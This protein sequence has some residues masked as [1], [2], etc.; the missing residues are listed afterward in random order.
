MNN[1]F[2]SVSLQKKLLGSFSFVALICLLVGLAGWWGTSQLNANLAAISQD[3]VPSL[4][5][6]LTLSKSLEAMKSSE[7]TLLDGTLSLQQRQSEY[8]LIGKARRDAE[9]AIATVDLLQRQG[10]ERQLWQTFTNQWNNW[11]QQL[12]AFLDL[13]KQY[14]AAQ[15]DNPAELALQAQKMLSSYQN[16]AIQL[17]ENIMDAVDVSVEKDPLQTKIGLWAQQLESQNSTILKAREELLT[18]LEAVGLSMVSIF[19]Y[20]EIEEPELAQEIYSIEIKPS[21][22]G[23]EKSIQLVL[24]PIEDALGIQRSMQ[25]HALTNSAPVLDQAQKELSAI[26]AAARK[27]MSE[28]TEN[29]ANTASKVATFLWLIITGGILCAMVLGVIFARSITGPLAQTVTMLEELERGHLDKRLKLSRG[30]EIGRMADALDRFADSL[31]QEIVQ[32][33]QQLAEGD[34][35]FEASPRD[36]QDVLRSTL[37]QLGSDLN[38]I[39]EQIQAAG[40]EIA[41]GSSQVAGSSASLSE[42]AAK[43]ASSME[44]ISSSMNEISSQ[45]NQSAQNAAQANLLAED[46][47]R[48]A[49]AGST[50]MAAMISAMSEINEA[51]QNINKIIKVIDEIAFQTNLLALNAAVEAARAGQHGKGFAVVAE[52]VRNL[53]ARSAKAAEETASL[54]EGSVEKASNG[55]QIAQKTAGALGEI[56]SSITKVTDL[57]SEIATASNEQANGVAQVNQGLHQID[58]IIQQNTSSSEES[59]AT[60]EELSSQAK[61]LRQML[62][63]FNLKQDISSAFST[64][65]IAENRNQANI[66]WENMPAEEA[67]EMVI[68]QD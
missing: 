23:V 14:D 9:Q 66:G 17:S 4:E 63:R 41:S 28:S 31:H 38:E 19:D 46:A 25:E 20:F 40:Q 30:D 58:Q 6:I 65:S 7:R 36:G 55:T 3:D 42:G 22:L 37:K 39:M 21:V 68:N 11:N 5:A 32:P 44:E 27:A 57:V 13:S 50:S 62:Q 35:T 24:K 34:L 33:L 18:Q 26:V 67:E 60:S 15:I 64:T 52:E 54:I 61:Y 48:A 29:A 53:A 47:R 2:S 49:D 12:Q 59:A 43:S 8:E 1:V 10:E 51:S 45:T 56:V 16:W